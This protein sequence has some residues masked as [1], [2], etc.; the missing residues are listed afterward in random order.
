MF[1]KC[2]DVLVVAQ[3]CYI[4]TNLSQVVQVLESWRFTQLN[5]MRNTFCQEEATD[6]MNNIT[7][8]TSVRSKLENIYIKK[9]LLENVS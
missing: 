1:K 9:K 5:T 7:S 3:W 2:Y 8:F 6:A 4:K